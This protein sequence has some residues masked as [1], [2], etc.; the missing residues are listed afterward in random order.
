MCTKLIWEHSINSPV[1]RRYFITSQTIVWYLTLRRVVSVL[2][3]ILL[4]M[5]SYSINSLGHTWKECDAD[6][7]HAAS[8]LN[9]LATFNIWSSAQFS[10]L[11]VFRLFRV[12]ASP[13]NYNFAWHLPVVLVSRLDKWEIDEERGSRKTLGKWGLVLGTCT[14]IMS[15]LRVLG[16]SMMLDKPIS[17][18]AIYEA[19]LWFLRSKWVVVRLTVS[20][21]ERADL[22][23][24][25]INV[26]HLLQFSFCIRSMTSSRSLFST[27]E[28]VHWLG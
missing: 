6:L 19:R 1:L 10:V 9:L 20:R 11:L 8:I 5:K 17:P 2:W 15:F 21:S 24:V 23:P 7:I 26:A 3:S 22:D 13:T 4:N 25:E 28:S 16:W 12:S 27:N 18:S 14:V